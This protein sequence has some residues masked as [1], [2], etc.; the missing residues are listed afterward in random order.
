MGPRRGDGT[1]GRGEMGSVGEVGRGRG[2]SMPAAL[3]DFGTNK[4]R[5]GGENKRS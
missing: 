2:L 3:P 5:T 4:E 1:Q